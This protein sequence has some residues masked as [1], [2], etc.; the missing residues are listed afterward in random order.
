MDN[1]KYDINQ[2]IEDIVA[3][4]TQKYGYNEDMKTVLKNIVKAIAKD[5]PYED[6]YRLYGVLKTTPIVV[7][8]PDTQITEKEL[9]LKMNGNVNPH[10]KDKEDFDQGEYGNRSISGGGAFVSTPIF[11]KDLN[12]IG[13]KK[14]IYVD[15]FDTSKPI[16]DENK[17]YFEMFQTG[18]NVPH[19]IHELGHAYASAESSYSIEDNIVTQ[20]MGACTNKY[21]VT[22]LGNGQYESE[23]IAMDGVF[24]EEGLNTNFEEDTLAKYLGLSLEDTLKLYGD[25]FPS[26]FYQPRISNMTRKL[27]KIG[28][29][30]DLDRWRVTGDEKALEGASR[31]FLKANFYEKRNKLFERIL[32]DFGD[33]DTQIIPARNHMFNHIIK[34]DILEQDESGQNIVKNSEREALESIESDFFPDAENMTPM[35]MI[36][37]ILLQFYD[38]GVNKYSIGFDKY[39]KMLNVI[40]AQGEGLIMQAE[41]VLSAEKQEKSEEQ[42]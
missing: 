35:D 42:K 33:P 39:S 2:E 27:T 28:I 5:K 25:V 4:V 31:P 13:E 3:E 7:L 1:F 20:R 22:P 19:L 34:E 21:K 9:S 15:G 14:Y 11:D 23:Q 36:N 32:E 10:I 41:Q 6:R 8:D 29:R 30:E 18:I 16:S 26:S 24:L 37:N 40:Q 12:I 38:A 17:K